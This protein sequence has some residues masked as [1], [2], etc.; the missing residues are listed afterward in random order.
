MTA[1]PRSGLHQRIENLEEILTPKYGKGL[2]M[3]IEQRV[4]ELEEIL[5]PTYGKGLQARIEK[6]E[7]TVEQ[8]Y[9]D[10]LGN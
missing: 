6:L 8:Q 5:K 10:G 1:M 4:E 2:Q 3:R 9:R 7:E